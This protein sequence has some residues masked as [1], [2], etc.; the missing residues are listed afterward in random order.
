MKRLPI[1]LLLVFLTFASEAGSFN[2]PTTSIIDSS[3]GANSRSGAGCSLC[4]SESSPFV[5]ENLGILSF[6][7]YD[8]ATETS[9]AFE[10]REGFTQNYFLEFGVLIGGETPHYNPTFEYYLP[11]GTQVLSPVDGFVT[12]SGWQPS[13]GYKQDDW[14]LFLRPS[15]ASSGSESD[16]FFE[17]DHVLSLDCDPDSYEVCDDE[18]RIN[19]EIVTPGMAIQAG[20]VIGY[21]GNYGHASADYPFGRTELAIG[22]YERDSG[23]YVTGTQNYC[24]TLYLSDSVKAELENEVTQF[25]ADL[26]AWSGDD[27]IY[28]QGEMVAPGCNSE[29]MVDGV[30]VPEPAAPLMFV[31][32]IACVTAIRSRC[33]L[34]NRS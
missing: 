3:S 31:T 18:L 6:G 7:P 15:E 33:A 17:F 11:K 28:A 10:F 25:L 24:L 26:E 19:G 14:E 27:A 32:A 13:Q 5:L 29:K 1:T 2:E 9:G 20:D 4:R 21:V 22:K 34:I 12:W 16:W 8:P 30:P 23:G